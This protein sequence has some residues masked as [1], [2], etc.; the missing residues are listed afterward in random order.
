[1]NN[2]TVVSLIPPSQVP[3]GTVFEKF[4][5]DEARVL[6][7]KRGKNRTIRPAE[8]R[9]YRDAMNAGKWREY[10]RSQRV[11]MID[12]H[13]V[14]RAGQHRI[15]AFLESDLDSIIFLVLRNATEEEVQNQDTG[16]TR[17]HRDEVAMFHNVPSFT[18]LNATKL[19]TTCRTIGEV[20]L[21]RRTIPEET[22]DIAVKYT[23]VL[24]IA[25]ALLTKD[26]RMLQYAAVLAAFVWAHGHMTNVQ[27]W[28]QVFR[29]FD[30]GINVTANSPIHRLRTL[31][32][33]ASATRRYDELFLKTLC[34]LKAVHQGKTQA[35]YL[36]SSKKHMENW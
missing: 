35:P 1:M 7:E 9:K 16:I 34:A 30:Q 4:T 32:E 33:K 31:T 19:I 14:L 13:G 11:L 12:A 28:E 25:E 6:F 23:P 27:D 15:K 5:K 20:T 3:T 17:N 18:K 22:A 24:Q 2:N 10:D 29:Q 8:V 21:G 26:G 36:T